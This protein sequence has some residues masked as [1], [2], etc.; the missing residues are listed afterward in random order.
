M[1]QQPPETMA[2]R[3]ARLRQVAA[4]AQQMRADANTAIAFAQQQL[5]QIDAEL[6]QAGVAPE[7]AEQEV[8]ALEVQLDR[9]ITDLEAQL[10]AEVA[11]LTKILDLAR[12]AQLVR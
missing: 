8:A 1:P 11:E 7:N 9:T 4:S 10:A 2:Q 5:T 6:K 12:A 3:I